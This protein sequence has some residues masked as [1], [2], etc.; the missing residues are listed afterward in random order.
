[1][2]GCWSY[3]LWWINLF[4]NIG[5][6]WQ[7][8]FTG[9]KTVCHLNRCFTLNV[10]GLAQLAAFLVPANTS[11][12]VRT[13]KYIWTAQFVRFTAF[14]S[15][16]VS[17]WLGLPCLHWTQDWVILN[18]GSPRLTSFCMV[19][20]L[21]FLL[22]PFSWFPHLLYLRRTNLSLQNWTIRFDQ[23]LRMRHHFTSKCHL[24]QSDLFLLI[25]FSGMQIH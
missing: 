2:E 12:S 18:I 5:L 7:S 4:W 16:V 24:L 17:I 8:Y 20:P 21:Y 25:F 10:A 13:A 1:M 11:L 6:I 22:L 19:F 9:S 14:F 3:A 15:W 23:T